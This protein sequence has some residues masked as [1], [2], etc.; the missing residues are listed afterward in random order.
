MGAALV[1]GKEEGI[2]VF[3]LVDEI[4]SIILARVEVFVDLLQVN[5]QLGQLV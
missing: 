5:V 3:H 4:L 1:S 2:D